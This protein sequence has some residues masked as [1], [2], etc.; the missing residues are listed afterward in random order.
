[1]SPLINT[2]PSP[3]Q[4][5]QREEIQVA[6]NTFVKEVK[7]KEVVIQKKGQAPEA[8]PCAMVVWATGIK[9]RPLVERLRGAIGTNIQ[10]NRNAILTDKWLEVKGAP[11]VYAMGDCASIEQEKLLGRLEEL[12]KGADKDGKGGINPAEFAEFVHKHATAY[13]QLSLYTVDVQE[14]FDKHDKN[15]DKLLS[16]DEFKEILKQAD[17]RLRSLP[18]TAQVAYQEGRYTADSFNTGPFS[19]ISGDKPFQY[20]HLGSLAYVGADQAVADFKD[21]APV[22]NFFQLG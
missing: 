9:S 4:H 16:L 8:W 2:R 14:V 7:H 17:N 10:H 6:P 1:M 20:K 13:P 15:A 19:R 18:A 3:E 21:V 22:L 5:F 12:F 11:G